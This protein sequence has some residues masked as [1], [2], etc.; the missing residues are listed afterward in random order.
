MSLKNMYKDRAIKILARTLYCKLIR[1][2]FTNRDVVNFAKEILAHM[3]HEVC[4]KT[5]RQIPEK[6]SS[7]DPGN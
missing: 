4:K 6:R 7:L 3:T 2:G 1:N 5:L